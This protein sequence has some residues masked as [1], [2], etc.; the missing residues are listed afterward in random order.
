MG[1]SIFFWRAEKK[2]EGWGKIACF[3]QIYFWQGLQQP[4]IID[5][6]SNNRWYKDE[7]EGRMGGGGG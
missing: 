4:G 5:M 2:I 1:C 7:E 6:S 3:Q